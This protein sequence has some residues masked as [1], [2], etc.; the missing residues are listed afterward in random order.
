MGGFVQVRS[1]QQSTRRAELEKTLRKVAQKYHDSDVA[2]LA[3]QARL[4][5]FTEV[6]K[7]IQQMIDKLLKEKQDEIK[8]KDWC[9][10][11]LNSN[12][13]DSDNKNRDKNDLTAKVDDLTMSIDTLDK[14]VSNLKAEITE[15]SVELKRAGEDREKQNKEFQ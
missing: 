5:A 9:I 12:E 15:L 14:D 4:D 10:E 3:T 13:R 6:K 8:H 11:E 2:A 7:S 1:K